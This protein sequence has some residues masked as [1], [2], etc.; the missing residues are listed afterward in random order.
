MQGTEAVCQAG[1]PGSDTV[2]LSRLQVCVPP[3]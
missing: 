2:T 3:C 1:A